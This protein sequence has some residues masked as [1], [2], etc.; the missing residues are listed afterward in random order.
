MKSLTVIRYVVAIAVGFTAAKLLDVNEP[1]SL[2]APCAESSGE[3][4]LLRLRQESRMQQQEIEWLL[5]MVK[6]GLSGNMSEHMQTYRERPLASQSQAVAPMNDMDPVSQRQQVAAAMVKRTQ[7]ADVALQKQ[8]LAE[9]WAID[10][11]L[12]NE[13]RALWQQAKDSL[14]EQEYMHGLFRAHL[15]NVMYVGSVSAEIAAQSGVKRGDIL[16][17][18]NGVRVFSR[19]DLRQQLMGIDRQ[20]SV[21]LVLDQQGQSLVTV[22][23]D[24][25]QHFEFYGESIAV[26]STIY[27]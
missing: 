9:G 2:A 21:E 27:P 8:A 19:D 15:P 14:S 4:E 13:R 20:A 12:A 23:N 3:G 6:A 5:R 10:G 7:M 22:V 24:I 1:A 18:V 11:Q 26:P 16:K 17:R 25:S